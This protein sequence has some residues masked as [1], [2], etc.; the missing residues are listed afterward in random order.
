MKLIRWLGALF[1]I[2]MFL[3]FLNETVRVLTDEDLWFL[4]Y[5]W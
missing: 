3:F 4:H 2:S 1:V 5:L